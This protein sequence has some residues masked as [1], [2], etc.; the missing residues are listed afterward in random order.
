MSGHYVSYIKK[1][2]NSNVSYYLYNDTTVKKIAIRELT[3]NIDKT[4]RIIIYKCKDD[5]FYM[6]NLENTKSIKTMFNNN[7]A[8]INDIKHKVNS[9]L[10]GTVNYRSNCYFNS[11]LVLLM[12]I[13]EFVYLIL[14]YDEINTLLKSINN[15]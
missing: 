6:N 10:F 4:Y 8:K 9:K 1:V 3:N 13:P 15:R 5:N 11:L 2:K 7:D 14:N 12:R